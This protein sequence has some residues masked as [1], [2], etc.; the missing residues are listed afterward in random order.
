MLCANVADGTDQ[1]GSRDWGVLLTRRTAKININKIDPFNL[2]RNSIGWAIW[3]RQCIQ[4][5]YETQ[6]KTPKTM[7]YNVEAKK[8]HASA[9]L[10]KNI[11][12]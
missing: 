5:E 10:N 11:S 9:I 3:G 1:L 8:K 6:N 4:A 12:K 2:K 7:G